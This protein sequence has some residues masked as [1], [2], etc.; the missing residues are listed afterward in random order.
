MKV[1]VGI[2]GSA[3]SAEAL[4]WAGRE[5]TQHGATVN[6]VT[7]YRYPV[8]FAGTGTAPDVAAPDAQSEAEAL[9]QS[10]RP[11]RVQT[12]SSSART[13]GVACRGSRSGR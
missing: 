9:Q 4:R 6:V 11:P 5:A 7:A 13:A 2:D 3:S 1:V 10:S 8:A 12:S